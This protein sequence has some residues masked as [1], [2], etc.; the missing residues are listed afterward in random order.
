MDLAEDRVLAL[1]INL[2]G[3]CKHLCLSATDIHIDLIAAAERLE[4]ALDDPRSLTG[5]DEVD[6][7]E[8]RLGED[9]LLLIQISKLLGLAP[10]RV[11]VLDHAHSLPD[12]ELRLLLKQAA[13]LELHLFIRCLLLH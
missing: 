13:R 2:V 11:K 4:I 12:C 7:T 3:I 9:G 1:V 8:H 5:H 6:R 10:S